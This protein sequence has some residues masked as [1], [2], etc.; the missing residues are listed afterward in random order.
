MSPRLSLPPATLLTLMT[1]SRQ[2]RDMPRYY[3]TFS[4]HYHF[5]PVS[6]ILPPFPFCRHTLY[7]SSHVTDIVTLADIFS[8]YA[9]ILQ[10]YSFF[11][12]TG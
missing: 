12:P 6:A 4:R 11:F 8:P 5:P 10:L 9:G 7:C 3:Y 2:R 1:D